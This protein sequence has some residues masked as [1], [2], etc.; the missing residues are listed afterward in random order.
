[1]HKFGERCY[2]PNNLCQQTLAKNCKNRGQCIP[3]D[4]RITVDDPTVCSCPDGFYGNQCELNETRID[5]SISVP[6]L[7]ESLLLHFIT[8]NSHT[9]PIS[10][11]LTGK[12]APHQRATTFKRIPFDR[13]SITIYWSNLFHILFAEHDDKMYLLLIQ[14][15]NTLSYGYNVSI[16]SSKRCPPIRELLNNTIINFPRL[17]RVKYYHMPCKERLDLECFHDEDQFMC[18]CTND[19]RAN[20][21]AFDHDMNYNC[22]ELSY[23]ENGGQCFQNAA[24]CPTAAICACPKCFLGT[25]CQLS[26]RSFG[27]SLDII[28]GYQIR[29]GISY[30]NQPLSI[31]ISGILTIIMLIIGL[32]NGTFSI[33]IFKRKI[34]CEFGCGIYL[35]MASIISILTML[36]FA[37]KYFLLILTQLAMVKDIGFLKGQCMIIDFLLKASLQIGD[38][39]FACVA[40]ER[41]ILTIKVNFK[42]TLSRKVAKWMVCFVCIFVIGTSIQEPFYRKLITD[43]DENRIWCTVVYSNLYSN[44]LN[45]YTTIISVIHFIGPFI[46]NIISSFGIITIA[47]VYRSKSQKKL[48]YCA[49]FCKQ[50]RQ[51]KYLIISPILLIILALPRI[52]L[53][54]TLDCMKSARESVM[55]YLIGYFISFVPPVLLFVVFVLPSDVYRKE[56]KNAL[57]R[58]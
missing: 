37:L 44:F 32:I 40:T 39:L 18:L 21:F 13:D 12:W 23:C 47:A 2:L 43:E 27:L 41:L 11:I 6:N 42:K 58:K 14:L 29:P 16:E 54:F 38:W 48:S 22:S 53:A 25:R 46:I 1:M 52:I 49:H 56:F 19:R 15:N 10:F 17:R 34:P 57:K 24:E 26:T 28:L 45:K 31:K 7:Q 4:N 55:L 3:R 30:N 33:L 20:C 51:H 50:L 35:L 5:I 9:G 8:V 36:L